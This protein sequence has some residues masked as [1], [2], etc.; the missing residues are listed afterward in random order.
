FV[1]IWSLIMLYSSWQHIRY[2]YYLAANVA[3]L[4]AVGLGGVLEWGYGPLHARIC[5]SG[6]KENPD[7]PGKEPEKT[8]GKREKPG[9]SSEK[10]ERKKAKG[11]HK[12]GDIL[13][14]AGVIAVLLLTLLFL[15]SSVSYSYAISSGKAIWAN[16]DWKESLTWMG[17]NTPATGV[18]YYK[19]YDMNTFQYPD[20]A[21]GVMSWWDYGHQIT[22]IAQ[23]IPNA[24]PFQRNV[25]GPNG[26]AAYF[27]AESENTANTILDNMGT[28]YVVTDIEM[29]T[30]PNGK[31][32]AMATWYNGSAGVFPYLNIYSVSDPTNSGGSGNIAAI[33]ENYYLTMISRLHNF[34]GSMTTP[35]TLYYVE[36]TSGGLS[37]SSYPEIVQAKAMN[38]TTAAAAVK[39][40]NANATSGARATLVSTS[41]AYPTIEVP[42]L[43]HY[44]LVHES[45]TNVYDSTT[46]DVKYVKVFEYVKGAAIKGTGIIE[47]P[48]VTNTGRN[49]TY[50]Q[51]SEN[52]MF[53]VPYATTGGSG[54]VKT[55]GKY[56]IIGTNQYFDVS[57]EAVDLGKTVN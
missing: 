52:G 10:Q 29:D 14:V 13:P 56:H 44:R 18:D 46:L 16:Q 54:E 24:N 23:R 33:G 19:I 8:A 12:D 36:Y 34:D 40:F 7:K 31:F 22:Y 32:W 4:G 26:S 35:T 41:V 9:K 21:Y 5:A 57:E 20:S 17:N 28:R 51:E 49:F 25:A 37:S 48:V 30:L 27:L 50:R 55:T 39:T 45:P 53:V 38:Y 42:A 15:Y 2:E 43:K 3:L 11:V 47:V 6:P 1:L